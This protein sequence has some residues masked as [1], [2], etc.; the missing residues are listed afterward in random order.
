MGQLAN[1]IGARLLSFKNPRVVCPPGRLTAATRRNIVVATPKRSGTHVVIDLILN[2]LAAYRRTP[3]YVDLDKFLRH[4][5]ARAG[6]MKMLRDGAGYV[7]KTHYPIGVRANAETDAAVA[8]IAANAHVIC[9]HR[10][11]AAILKS[12]DKWSQ[13]SERKVAAEKAA[14]DI[15]AFW[16]FWSGRADADVAFE[17]LF[18]AEGARK[19]LDTAANSTGIPAPTR[20]RATP[21]PRRR[22]AIYLNKAATRL[23]GR[24][25]PRIDTTIFTLQ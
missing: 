2:N 6:E 5:D 21:D 1:L 9:V 16:G 11:R 3:L 17:Q 10:D 4:R 20:R 25:A 8:Q 24:W 22:V 18:T 23:L 14:A 12:L 13:S 7:V 15:D 19:L